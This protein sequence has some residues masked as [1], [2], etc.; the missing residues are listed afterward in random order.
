MGKAAP[1]T[2]KTGITRNPN[3]PTEESS[4]TPHW[5]AGERPRRSSKPLSYQ[6]TLIDN[7][8]VNSRKAAS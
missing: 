2:A 7:I 5:P 6:G 1:P 3:I 4:P 8:A